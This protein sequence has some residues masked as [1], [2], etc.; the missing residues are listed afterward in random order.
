M[1]EKLINNPLDELNN[2]PPKKKKKERKKITLGFDFKEFFFGKEI[3]LP[4]CLLV[5]AMTMLIV[6]KIAMNV[7]PE[8]TGGYLGVLILLTVIF[9]IPTYLF[10]KFTRHGDISKISRE[11]QIKPPRAEH[12]FLLFFVVIY[13]I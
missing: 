8:K 1:S 4:P 11:L 13:K 3:F 5:I 6:F 7:Y 9:F 10:Y 12:I 2:T